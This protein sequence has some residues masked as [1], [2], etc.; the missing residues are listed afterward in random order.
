M[1]R[2]RPLRA[3]PSSGGVHLGP[4]RKQADVAEQTRALFEGLDEEKSS[5]AAELAAALVSGRHHKRPHV[6]RL[7]PVSLPAS[8]FQSH[9]IFRFP[10]STLVHHPDSVAQNG[11]LN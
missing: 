5:L 7:S 11:R 8:Y 10:F 2:L 6:R 1:Q 4:R 3:D 9:S